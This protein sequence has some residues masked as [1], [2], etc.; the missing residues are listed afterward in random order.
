MLLA[1]SGYSTERESCAVD[2]F[3]NSRVEGLVLTVADEEKSPALTSLSSAGIPFVLMFN[4]VKNSSY[5]TISIDNRKAA[6][7]LVCNILKLGHRRIAM[8]AAGFPNRPI[9]RA[10]GRLSGCTKTYGVNE[11][12]ITEVGLKT[13][14]S[15]SR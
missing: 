2:T 10:T 15:V 9:H 13:R 5:S 6:Y 11:A 1:S 8:I 3:L 14:I 7:E 12:S 4:P